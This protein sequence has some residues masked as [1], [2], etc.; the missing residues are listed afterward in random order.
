MQVTHSEQ[1]R[2]EGNEAE[3]APSVRQS[4]L[5][6]WGYIGV[7][8]GIMENKMETNITYLGYFGVILGKPT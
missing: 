4:A 1:Y 2:S 5:L 3:E 8:L 7:I 6:Y